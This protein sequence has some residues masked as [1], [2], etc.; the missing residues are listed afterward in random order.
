[1][2]LRSVPITSVRR[3]FF[4]LRHCDAPG[5]NLSSPAIAV[6]VTGVRSGQGA[7]AAGGTFSPIS[8][9]AQPKLSFYALGLNTAGYVPGPYI[10]DFTAGNGAGAYSIPFVVR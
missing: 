3:T 4:A 8:F 7:I 2:R 6:R 9:P 5:A 10:L 1:M